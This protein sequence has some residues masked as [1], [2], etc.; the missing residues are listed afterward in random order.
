MLDDI[1]I[2]DD[3]LKEQI[4]NRHIDIFPIQII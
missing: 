3:E 1:Y 2:E 4:V